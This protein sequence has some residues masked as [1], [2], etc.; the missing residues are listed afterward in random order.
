MLKFNSY[1]LKAICGLLQCHLNV[2]CDC[3]QCKLEWHPQ[4]ECCMW[5]QLVKEG[6][7]IILRH[8]KSLTN[9]VSRVYKASRMK[10]KRGSIQ[11]AQTV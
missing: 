1:A 8:S 4:R 9:P 11:F 3:R 7:R 2:L 6:S 10:G 5:E